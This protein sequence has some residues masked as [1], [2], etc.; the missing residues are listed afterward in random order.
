MRLIVFGDI[1]A[2]IVALEC[3]YKEALRY[4]P[5]RVIHLG[6]LGG[7]APF[8]NEV[9]EFMIEHNIQG[10]QGN[11]D[12]NVAHDT[13][14]CGCRYEGPQQA[15]LSHLSFEWTKAHTSKENRIYMAALPFSISLEAA[16]RRIR[17]FHATPGGQ[18][19]LLV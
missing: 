6:D 5:D 13:S 2:N 18:Q 10:V 11:Y 9:T 7:Y 15:E 8:V 19:P 12:F 16:G 14:D 4:E 17:I 1:H 3:C